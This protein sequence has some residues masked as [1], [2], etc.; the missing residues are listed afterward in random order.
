MT[1]AS[2]SVPSP[3]TAVSQV[4]APSS[5]SQT[6]SSAWNTAKKV[7]YAVA[8]VFVGILNIPFKMWSIGSHI[9]SE[10]K[11][12][13]PGSRTENEA[14]KA[15]LGLGVG[16]IGGLIGGVFAS[17]YGM[18]EASEVGNIQNQDSL[19]KYSSLTP[20]EKMM[21]HAWKK[22]DIKD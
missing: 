3:A 5:A 11:V 12:G 22:L 17:H 21:A 8:S 4:G 7:G 6:Q 14:E 18:Y 20:L 9:L 1:P 16:I 19:S 10:L 13:S 2:S 15:I